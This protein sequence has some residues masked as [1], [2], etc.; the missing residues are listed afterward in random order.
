MRYLREV[1]KMYVLWEGVSVHLQ[2]LCS[3]LLNGLVLEV[4]NQHVR[5]NLVAFVA[6]CTMNSAVH[7]KTELHF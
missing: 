6:R 1:H 2:V 7:S 5:A 4:H 3:E